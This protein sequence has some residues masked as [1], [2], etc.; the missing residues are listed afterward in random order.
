VHPGRATGSPAPTSRRWRC[1]ALPRATRR[2]A[3]RS[4]TP[5]RSPRSGTALAG[6][7]P[8]QAS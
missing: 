3:R 2:R 5:A 7:S 8:V 6:S 4:P 1:R